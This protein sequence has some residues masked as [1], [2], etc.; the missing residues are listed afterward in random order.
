[1]RSSRFGKSIHICRE[2]GHCCLQNSYS[3]STAHPCSDG[4]E[5]ELC[6]DSTQ[7][8]YSLQI[9]NAGRLFIL[10]VGEV[11]RI[12]ARLSDKEPGHREALFK[13]SMGGRERF[14]NQ[15]RSSNGR[16]RRKWLLVLKAPVSSSTV[17][18]HHA[19]RTASIRNNDMLSID[20]LPTIAD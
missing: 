8:T 18:N 2:L 15:C 10:A 6:D 5:G 14:G 1:V 7:A 13:T 20:R 3:L 17:I 19:T 9:C 4:R 12:E 11:D 16:F